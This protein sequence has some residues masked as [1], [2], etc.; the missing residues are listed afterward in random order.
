[1]DH[2][3][4]WRLTN[5]E[6]YLKGITLQWKKYKIYKED[7]DHDHCEFCW[8]KFTEEKVKNTLNEGYATDDNNHWICKQCFDDFKKMFNWEIK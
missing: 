8:G 6:N 3:N 4:D 7:W 5:Q 1:V 2:K